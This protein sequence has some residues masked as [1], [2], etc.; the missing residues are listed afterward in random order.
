MKPNR[1]LEVINRKNMV[2]KARNNQ[3]GQ[4]WYFD[5]RSLTIKSD[6]Y[7]AWSWNVMGNGAQEQLQI[8][9]TNSNWW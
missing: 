9:G 5:Q 2:V 7:K 3:K 4:V 6:L 8:S 1:Y